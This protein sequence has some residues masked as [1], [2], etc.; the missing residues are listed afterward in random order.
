MGIDELGPVGGAQGA[1]G[2]EQPGQRRLQFL[3]GRQLGTGQVALDAAGQ[4]NGNDG[5][6]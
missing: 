6:F 3:R 1:G 4:T 2:V 5:A